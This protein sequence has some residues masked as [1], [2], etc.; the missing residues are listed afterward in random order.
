[1]TTLVRYDDF[2][3]QGPTIEPLDLDEVKKHLRFTSTSEDTLLDVYISMARQYFEEHTGRQIM[4]ATWARTVDLTPSG[5]IPLPRPP[6]QSIVSITHDDGVT[7]MDPSAYRVVAPAGAFATPG[8]VEAVSGSWPGARGRI[9]Y[10]AGYGDTPGDVPEI[11][12]GALLFL[13]GHFHKFRAEV[14]EGNVQGSS[15]SLSTIPIG[16]EAIMRMFRYASVSTFGPLRT[17]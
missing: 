5:P 17:L 1:M 8:Y 15:G 9:V 6:L 12:R 4:T 10:R 16:A 3:V 14:Y 2:L 13:V 11:V 7:L